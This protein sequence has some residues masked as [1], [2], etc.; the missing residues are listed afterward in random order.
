[1]SLTWKSFSFEMFVFYCIRTKYS[2]KESYLN[3][4]VSR[5]RFRIRRCLNFNNKLLGF[6]NM[7]FGITFETIIRIYL[8]TI[9]EISFTTT[10]G[11]ILRATLVSFL[12]I[13]PR[14]ILKTS[15]MI[16]LDTSLRSPHRE[17]MRFNVTISAWFTSLHDTLV[18]LWKVSSRLISGV[19]KFDIS[20]LAFSLLSWSL[21]PLGSLASSRVF[22]L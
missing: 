1:M 22:S 4:T 9:L 11:I 3:F 18:S 21:L 5:G 20:D 7:I 16:P 19:W 14:Y 12:R 2:S 17:R 8:E 15:L 10:L 13:S 6:L